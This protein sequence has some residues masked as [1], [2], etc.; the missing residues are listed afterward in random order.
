MKQKREK[1]FKDLDDLYEDEYSEHK[2][3]SA[4]KKAFLRKI[5]DYRFAS[6]ALLVIF[7]VGFFNLFNLS[8]VTRDAEERTIIY[9]GGFV[10]INRNT[11]YRF[12]PDP[13][14]L[15]THY[16]SIGV[17][18]MV[19]TL[20]RDM[21]ITGVRVAREYEADCREGG[22]DLYNYCEI[23]RVVWEAWRERLEVDSFIREVET[24]S[25]PAV[26]ARDYLP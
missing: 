26:S 25:P 14:A 17:S 1:L 11:Y 21:Q 18:S 5:F 2:E 8:T 19:I 22:E 13:D 7:F 10:W 24:T 3:K 6:L 15:F 9:Y 4:K 16:L 23:G 20:D 12:D